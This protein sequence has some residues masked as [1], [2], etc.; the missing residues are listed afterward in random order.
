MRVVQKSRF[1][2]GTNLCE[3]AGIYY[4]YQRKGVPLGVGAGSLFLNGSPSC[5]VTKCHQS[6]K[7]FL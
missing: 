5:V 3:K 2:Q 7:G 6:V 1:R 4:Q